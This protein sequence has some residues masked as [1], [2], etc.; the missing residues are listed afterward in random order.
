MLLT[1]IA[2]GRYRSLS[3][4]H[5]AVASRGTRRSRVHPSSTQIR[6]SGSQMGTLNSSDNYS[7]IYDPRPVLSVDAPGW[8]LAATWHLSFWKNLQVVVAGREGW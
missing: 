1:Q 5:R 2:P 7:S 8:Q 6:V 4:D 3:R